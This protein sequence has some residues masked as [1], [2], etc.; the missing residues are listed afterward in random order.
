M[1]KKTN[2]KSKERSERVYECRVR[3]S[4][5]PMKFGVGFLFSL[6][7]FNNDLRIVL[8]YNGRPL[9]ITDAITV[10]RGR[11]KRAI[12]LLFHYD[13]YIENAKKKE[14]SELKCKNAHQTTQ[15][16]KKKRESFECE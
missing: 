5:S 11:K 1:R 10:E 14:E 13:E 7:V 2:E 4:I 12:C 6:C 15:R 9:F 16:L 3:L 8:V